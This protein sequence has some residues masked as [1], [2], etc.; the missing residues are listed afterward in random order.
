MATRCL[1]I[2]GKERSGTTALRSMIASTG[3]FD[4][5][6]ELFAEHS[7]AGGHSEFAKFVSA[8][9]IDRAQMLLGRT[10]LRL[11]MEW[12][13]HIDKSNGGTPLI[14]VKYGYVNFFD[15]WWRVRY[16]PA[17][18]QLAQ[19]EG[20]K[21]IHMVRRNKI[22]IL[23]SLQQAMQSNSWVQANDRASPEAYLRPVEM[24]IDRAIYKIET[25]IM[26]EEVV[27]SYLNDSPHHLAV[28]TI[29]YEDLFARD[30]DIA[31]RTR[32]SL[33]EFLEVREDQLVPKVMK[34]DNRALDARIS[35]YE[36]LSR[37]LAPTKYAW[38]LDGH[39]APLASTGATR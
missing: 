20:F 38:M 22:E 37:L 18:M 16:R 35:N 24:D 10:K 4:D 1:F 8:Q 30:V 17:M 36:E 11:F 31:M 7:L 39:R 19:G 32:R 29:E 25:L 15:S 21:Y 27:R 13:A 3:K 23:S 9:E 34:Q 6:H 5:Y 26:E 12:I 14:D 33:A 2:I 28:H